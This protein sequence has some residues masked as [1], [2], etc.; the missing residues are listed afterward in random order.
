MKQEAELLRKESNVIT[1]DP[2]ESFPS[3]HVCQFQILSIIVGNNHWFHDTSF[4]DESYGK[5]SNYIPDLKRD[6]LISVVPKVFPE[7]KKYDKLKKKIYLQIRQSLSTEQI[8]KLEEYLKINASE[9]W[10]IVEESLKKVCTDQRKARKLLECFAL[11]CK[12][13]LPM[14]FTRVLKLYKQDDISAFG[15]VLKN[16]S[17]DSLMCSALERANASEIIIKNGYNKEMIGNVVMIGECYYCGFDEIRDMD[18][19][20]EVDGWFVDIT[21]NRRK[22]QKIDDDYPA[23]YTFQRLNF[24]ENKHAWRKKLKQIDAVNFEM[25]IQYDH[26]MFEGVKNHMLEII[27][28][29]DFAQ[30]TKEKEITLWYGVKDH[31]KLVDTRLLKAEIIRLNNKINVLESMQKEQQELQSSQEQELESSQQQ[32]LESSEQH[33]LKSSE[34]QEL[35][36]SEQQELESSQQ[37]ELP[38]S[39]QQEL[40]SLQQQEL[41]SSE[42]QE[43]ES[44][45]Q[46]ELKSSEEQE[47]ESSQQQELPQQ[48]QLPLPEQQ[49][50]P[51]PEQQQL[52]L[53][54]HQASQLQ[55]QQASQL[56]LQQESQI[57]QVSQEA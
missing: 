15:S 41:K 12:D 31:D 42:Q 32:E 4:M 45:E 25:R 57:Q 2:R 19:F 51:L 35:P 3:F 27:R 18:Y 38:S 14:I 43:L 26:E 36:S 17:I 47:L 34:Q 54:E 7:G 23:Q 8:N 16:G 37:Q 56:Q 5:I 40:E 13:G 50:L 44:S 30:W 48:Q 33:E 11:I 46:Q 6:Q 10:E 24:I 28:G 29:E 1:V 21:D 20:H 53:P 39:Q 55:L 52:P 22:L 49:Q 9:Q